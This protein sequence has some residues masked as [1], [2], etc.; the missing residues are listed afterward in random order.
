MAPPAARITDMHTCPAVT[1]V[2]PHVGGPIIPPCEPTVLIGFLPAARVSD[3]CTCIGPPD[4]IIQGSATVSIGNLPAARISDQT[5]HGGVIVLGCF[6]VIIGG[7]SVQAV[8]RGNITIIVNRVNK[9]ITL[10][11]SQEFSGP[12]ATQSYVDRA[13]Q[14]INNTWSGPTQFE[15]QTYQVNSQITGRLAAAGASPTPGANQIN[16]VQTSDPFVVTSQQ[17]P[18]NQPFYGTSP[19]HQHST[20][21]DGPQLTVA[22]EF[23]HSMGLP[24][25]YSEGPR[26]ADGTRNV[27]RTGPPGGLMGHIEP[28]SKPTPDN[29]NSLVTG[30][31]LQPN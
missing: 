2:V 22:H 30:N 9:T 27:V 24:D 5:A 18:S 29:F 11:G 26:N 7:P 12:G 21:M 4:V 13:T 23:G 17:D 1:G 28:G 14:L 3:M 16:V 8:M 19:G 10:V 6:T 31:G 25:E 15:G 20:D